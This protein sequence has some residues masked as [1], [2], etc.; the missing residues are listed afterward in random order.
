MATK[1]F[2]KIS[3]GRPA[4][5]DEWPWMAAIMRRGYPNAYCGGALITDRHVLTAAH[6]THQFDVADIY[7]RLGEYD[8]SEYNETR[9]RD[10]RAASIRQHID[11]N[12]ATYENDIAVIK[13]ERP[14]IFNTYIWPV[15]MPPLGETWEGWIGIVTGWGTTFFGG[16]HSNVLMEVAVPIW[17][18]ERCKRAFVN[19]VSDEF[20]C[21][22][23]DEGGRDSCQG[24]SG[25][26]LLVQLPNRRW[27][28]VGIVSWGLRCGE[29]DHPGI[30][31][32]VNKYISWVVENSAF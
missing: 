22:G 29:K 13:F 28:I 21:A 24:D 18:H 11:F 3:G 31:T 8:F 6:C 2:P 4:K 27:V 16:P 7:V 20:L 5:P 26:P 19:R 9:L 30:Y 12:P 17:N 15:C 32:R 10:F 1:Q 23:S 25:G 14:T